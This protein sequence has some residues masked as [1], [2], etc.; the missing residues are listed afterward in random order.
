MLWFIAIEHSV[1]IFKFFVATLYQNYS[2][3]G[4]DLKKRTQVQREKI[5]AET[6]KISKEMVDK[7][8]HERHERIHKDREV[9]ALKRE[10]YL[11]DALTKLK[12]FDNTTASRLEQL[13]KEEKGK[14]TGAIRDYFLFKT[15]MD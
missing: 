2:T 13:R 4:V 7:L 3:E 10:F 11:F 5:K 1:F 12:V 9:Q 14:Q 15:N 8:H 6:K